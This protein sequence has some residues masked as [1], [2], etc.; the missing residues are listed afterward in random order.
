[1]AKYGCPTFI[2][3]VRELHGGMQARVQDGGESSE[4]FSVSNG[5]KQGYVL[6]PTLLS[7][8]FSDMLTDAFK[9]VDIGIGT[10][11]RFGGSVFNLRRLQEKIKVQSETINDLMFANYCTLRAIFE[12]SMHHSVDRFYDSCHSFVLTISRKRSK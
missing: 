1:M 4:P 3:I 7:L 8:V 10:R 5:V 6:A 12:A 2:T 11:W 9:G